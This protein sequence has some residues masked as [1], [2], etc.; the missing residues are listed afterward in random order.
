MKSNP[1]SFSDRITI[2]TAEAAN[3]LG[4]T[5]PTVQQLLNSGKLPSFKLGKRR[6]IILSDL[7]ELARRMRDQYQKR[8]KK[9]PLGL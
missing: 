8:P 5:K 3:A 7:E 6:L 1:V 4:V 2:S 9:K